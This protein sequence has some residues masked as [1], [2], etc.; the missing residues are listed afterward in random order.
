MKIVLGALL[1]AGMLGVSPSAMSQQYPAKPVHIVVPFAPGGGSDF[2]ARFMAQRL[3][4]A[5]GKQFIVEN[6]PGAGGVLGIEQGI[7]AAP[8][9]YTLTLIASSY[10]VNPSV[11]KIHFD[12]IADI[13]PV[14][15]MSQGPLLV[16]VRPSLP[17]KTTKG[18]IALAKDSHQRLFLP[19]GADATRHA[20]PARLVAEEARDAK[21]NPFEVRGVIEDD[22]GAGAERG[23]NGPRAFEAERHIEL[24]FGDERAGSATKEHCT[25][26]P[27][28][29][30][31]AG[32]LHQRA[33]GRAHRHFVQAGVA[34]V[35]GDAKQARSRGLRRAD[36]RV[37]G[38]SEVED[39][40]HVD[41]RLHVVDE[42]GHAEEPDGDWKRRLVARLSP[43]PFDRV[44]ERGLLAAD[45]R[46]CATPHL[47]VERHPRTG[48]VST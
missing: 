13:T 6:K 29:M 18:L 34:H 9:G 17:V 40:E 14:I 35:A 44:E 37:L 12:P 15:Q 23:P 28:L 45:V 8:D 21:Q 41:Q 31:A 11:Y 30:Q 42:R 2:I 25:Q 26:R 5:L 10:T 7:K 16:V 19:S 39:L 38:A 47:D 46:T 32:K 24:R 22:H 48:D 43:L 20:L 3:T 33:Q 27:A 4:D 1:A 36:L